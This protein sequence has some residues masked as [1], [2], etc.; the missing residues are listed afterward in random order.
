MP[1]IEEL[2]GCPV[3]LLST[4]PEREDTILVRDPFQLLRSAQLQFLALDDAGT[5]DEEKW[6]VEPDIP[7]EQLHARALAE[8]VHHRHGLPI[9]KRVV[10]TES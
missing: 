2:V 10:A 4:S 3:T 1:R 8:T 6:L 9:A 7:S 5:S